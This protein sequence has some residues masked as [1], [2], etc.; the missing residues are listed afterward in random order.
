VAA[1]A[2]VPRVREVTGG[3]VPPH[4]QHLTRRPEPVAMVSRSSDPSSCAARNRQKSSQG[5]S[6]RIQ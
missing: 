3:P 1:A 6:G 2:L 4:R 5:M